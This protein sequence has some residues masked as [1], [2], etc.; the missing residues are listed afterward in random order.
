[1]LGYRTNPMRFLRD[2]DEHERRD[3]LNKVGV[4]PL[5]VMNTIRWGS[6]LVLIV[7]DHGSG[8][9]HYWQTT[10]LEYKDSIDAEDRVL[11]IGYQDL[12]PFRPS[13]KDFFPSCFTQMI[14]AKVSSALG[15]DGAETNRHFDAMRYWTELAK[16]INESGQSSRLIVLI[17]GL[18]EY[19]EYDLKLR[20]RAFAELRG[21]MLAIISI[22]VPSIC[23]RLFVTPSLLQELRQALPTPRD[24]RRFETL[25]LNWTAKDI[26]E[27][28]E[29]RLKSCQKDEYIASPLLPRLFKDSTYELF[30]KW[31][32]QGRTPEC[33]MDALDQLVASLGQS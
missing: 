7:G 27:L 17:D 2:W 8:K 15:I 11:L 9:T 23:V 33:A 6:R 31:L 30:E 1:M 26:V 16:S 4:D 14:C 19:L 25:E 22:S 10:G 18:H 29:E 13:E 28:L 32:S 5:Q 21:C 3:L 20:D 12:V 24:H